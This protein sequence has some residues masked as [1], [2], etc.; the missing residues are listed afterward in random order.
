M[1]VDL[2]P[3]SSTREG[4]FGVVLTHTDTGGTALYI[5]PGF[6]HGFV[7]LTDE[8]SVEYLISSIHVPEAARGIRYDDPSLAIAWP[9][10]PVVISERDRALPS[11]SEVPRG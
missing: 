1:I 11:L 7:T 8:T 2:R 5:P 9:V 6:A 3:G 4:W 10:T